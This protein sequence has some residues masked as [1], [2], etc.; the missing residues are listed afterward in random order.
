MNDV[1]MAGAA[2]HAESKHH[3]D[4]NYGSDIDQ[5]DMPDIISEYG[6]DIDEG[7]LSG[8]IA[9]AE[10]QATNPLVLESIEAESFSELLARTQC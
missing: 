1:M 6:S 9:Q 8:I 2:T 3:D 10:S 4:S 7:A 5:N